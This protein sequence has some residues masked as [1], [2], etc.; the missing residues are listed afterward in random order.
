MCFVVLVLDNPCY[1]DGDEVRGLSKVASNSRLYESAVSIRSGVAR[2][3]VLITFYSTI[4]EY[5]PK[6]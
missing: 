5:L 2:V 4:H 3:G 1:G 6:V